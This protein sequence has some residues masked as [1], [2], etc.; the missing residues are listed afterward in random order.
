[1]IEEETERSN[2]MFYSDTFH[3]RMKR[4]EVMFYSNDMAGACIYVFF[5]EGKEEEY[6]RL[7]EADPM[8]RN[9]STDCRKNR[10]YREI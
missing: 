3:G 4:T 7:G 9:G 8:P 10:K 2:N 1:M 6:T 5:S